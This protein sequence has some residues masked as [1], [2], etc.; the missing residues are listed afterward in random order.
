MTDLSLSTTSNDVLT[1]PA[2]AITSAQHRLALVVIVLTNFL[3]SFGFRLWQSLFNNFAVQELGVRADQIGLVQSIREIPGLLGFSVGLLA[4]L[5]TEMRIAGLSVVLMGVGIAMTGGVSSLPGLIASTLVMSIGFH[6]F[7]SSNSSAVLLL[8]G[9]DDAPRTLGRL[10][11]LS[12]VTALAGAGVVFL[13]LDALGFRTLFYA[14]GALVAVGGLA[15]LPWG[16]QPTRPVRTRRRTPVR[17][18]YWLYYTLEFLMGSRRHIF[19]TFAIFLLVREY[20][21]TAQTITV[22]FVI[23][24]LIGTFLYQQFG[25]I[26]A[27]FGERRMLTLN[28]A[29]LIFVFLGYAYIPLLPVLYVLFVADQVLFGFR[30]AL[31][32]YFQKIAIRPEE[33]TPNISL[34]QTINHIAAV[35]IPVV[36]GVVWETIGSRYTFLVGVGIAIL[37]LTLVQWMHTEA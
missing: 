12:A 6:F 28:F 2:T 23:N 7:L 10:S 3:L 13:A 16:R 9:E 5:L 21:V 8:F 18:R 11:S 32:S 25:K 31:S 14:T 1:D 26:I 27:R 20:R 4:L 24:N 36:G 34:G 29:L 37:S 30:I 22:L 19:T 33:I 15:L 17:R 35:I